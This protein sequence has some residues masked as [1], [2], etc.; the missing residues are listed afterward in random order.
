MSTWFTNLDLYTA[1][2]YK[3][4]NDPDVVGR[5]ES[6]GPQSEAQASHLYFNQSGC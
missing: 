4:E 6:M 5:V 3:E 2:Y 1:Y